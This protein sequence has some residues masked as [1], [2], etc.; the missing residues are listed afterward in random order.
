MK[1]SSI[2]GIATGATIGFFTSLYF[3]A[4]PIAYARPSDNMDDMSIESTARIVYVDRIVEVPKYIRI[5]RPELTTLLD[6]TSEE[7]LYCLAQNIYFES[8]GESDIGQEAVAWVT[9]N[10]V[11]SED[12]PNN[13]CDVVWESGQF[14]WTHDGKSDRPRNQEAW[15]K[16]NYIAK[17]VLENYNTGI[18]PTEGSTYFH[19]D[20]SKPYWRNNFNRVVQIDNHIFYNDIEDNG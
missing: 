11:F 13:I 3:S 1:V 15:D 18:D 14:S 16:A 7:N 19:A 2:M 17:Y 10:R 4:A 12:F 9:I 20:Y 6:T 8:R 5:S